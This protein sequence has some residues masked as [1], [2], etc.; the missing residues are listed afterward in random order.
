MSHTILSA[1]NHIISTIASEG[2]SILPASQDPFLYNK[3]YGAFIE[4]HS[5]KGRHLTWS[6]LQ[7]AVVAL[8]NGLY[9]RGQYRTCEFGVLDGIAGLVGV[10]KMGVAVVGGGGGENGAVGRRGVDGVE[11]ESDSGN[12]DASADMDLT[13]SGVME[14]SKS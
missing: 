12:T 14:T 6:Y 3:G 2:D 8:Y 9:L 10:G 1:Y 13:V 11:K 4:A 7:G 5:A